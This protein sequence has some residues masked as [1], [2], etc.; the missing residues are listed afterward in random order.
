MTEKDVE[1]A[2]VVLLYIGDD[3]GAKLS[4]LLQKGLKPGARIVSHRFKL[5]DWK[6]K[7]IEAELTE[8][9]RLSRAGRLAAP[10]WADQE[11]FASNWPAP[12]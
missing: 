5:G 8:A 7:R 11:G 3:L 9:A 6:H 10:P 4:P 1:E 2:T 12:R